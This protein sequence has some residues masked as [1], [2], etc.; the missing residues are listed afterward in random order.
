MAMY[1]CATMRT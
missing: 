1:L